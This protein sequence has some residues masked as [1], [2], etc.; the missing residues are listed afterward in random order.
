MS[1]S[2]IANLAVDPPLVQNAAYRFNPADRQYIDQ[3]AI[4]AQQ[5]LVNALIRGRHAT[6]VQVQ[7]SSPALLP[8]DVVCLASVEEGDARVTKANA[9]TLGNAI[10]AFGVVVLAAA[11]GAFALIAIGGFL[12]PTLT[13]LQPAA[14]G[15]VRANTTTGHCE[16]VTSLG[17]GDFGIGSVDASG[18]MQ[19]IPGIGASN[20]VSVAGGT[21]GG[22]S[23][24]L[25]INSSGVFAGRTAVGLKSTTITDTGTQ[26]Q[27]DA[28]GVATIINSSTGILDDVVATVGGRPASRI[29][30]NGGSAVSVTSFTS[31]VD[32]RRP[33]T[34]VNLTGHPLTLTNQ[35]GGTAT[36]RIVTGTGASD[37]IPDGALGLLDY[38]VT[39]NR[40]H[41]LSGSGGSL[42]GS[43]GDLLTSNGVGG[44]TAVP[45]GTDGQIPRVSGSVVTFEDGVEV[46]G[47]P[48]DIQ[49]Q[50]PS[51]TLIGLSPSSGAPGTV[52]TT[53]G[54]AFVLSAP[55]G[56]GSG[57]VTMG[58]LTTTND[59][60]LLLFHEIDPSTLADG[61]YELTVRVRG[62][63]G[64]ASGAVNY[65]ATGM[66][67]W[68][69]V[70]AG[71]AVQ[72]DPT[73]NEVLYFRVFPETTVLATTAAEIHFATGPSKIQVRV[74]GEAATVIDWKGE[75]DLRMSVKIS[76]SA[77]GWG[78][79]GAVFDPATLSLTG[80][81]RDFSLIWNGT[82]SAGTSASQSLNEST[83]P[84]TTGTAL[85]GHATALFNGTNSVLEASGTEDTYL[86]ST[87]GSGWHLFKANSAHTDAGAGSRENNPQFFVDNNGVMGAG[88]S[89]SGAF[90]FISDS[91]NGQ[92]ENVLA[93]ATGAYHLFQWKFHYASG[94]TLSARL[95]SGSWN[96]LTS[97]FGSGLTGTLSGN[98]ISLGGKFNTTTPFFDGTVAEQGIS[99]TVISDAD[100]DNIKTYI[101][102]RY[103]LS[104]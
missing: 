85:N 69:G 94:M 95:D 2:Q 93:C 53:T 41:L 73:P 51:G 84:P 70:I 32:K 1:G 99:D 13:G 24:D 76:G 26:L 27:I 11:P 57:E 72:M 12:P 29:V 8:G 83:H 103:G 79:V 45:I 59:G 80:W 3:Q 36:N 87:A 54:T 62:D 101:N 16:R 89:S 5:H 97:A 18:Y 7:S 10:S 75:R 60:G 4:G 96:I 52:V 31:G 91:S 15:F 98:T 71:V 74:R 14:R 65:V 61:I 86:N 39:D 47:S 66:R 63:A 50:G 23:G 88:F 21:P 100:F 46:G 90:A 81:W 25:Q 38:N 49:V 9:T 68:F 40:W 34:V 67:V 64:P 44:A 42:P 30:F 82:A 78:G 37:P 6:Y 17:D 28:D 55:S 58:P 43:A 20:T 77:A 22:S 104:L 92:T 35:S 33:L 48:G 102:A 56:G 19:V